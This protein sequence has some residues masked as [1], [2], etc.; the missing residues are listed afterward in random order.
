MSYQSL[1]I[2]Q[3]IN[4]LNKKY[5]LPSLQREFVWDDRQI[6]RLFDS[7]MRGYPISSFLFWQPESST[8]RCWTTYKFL[9]EIRDGGSHSSIANLN[10][11]NHPVFVLDGQQRLTAL[12]IG[13]RGFYHAKE[14]YRWWNNPDAYKATRLHIDLIRKGI[15]TGADDED[16]E[17]HFR[18]SFTDSPAKTTKKSCWFEVGKILNCK[19]RDKLYACI[20]KVQRS[21]PKSASQDARSS[22]ADTLRTLYEAIFETPTIFY[23]TETLPDYDRVLDI[24]VRANEAGT[25]LT[26]SDLLLSTMIAN[27]AHEDARKEIHTFVDH[28]ND[29]LGRRNDLDK[30]FVIKASF[31]LCDLP[32]KYNITSFTRRNL[33]VVEQS[34]PDIKSALERCLNLVNSFGIDR[35]NLSSAN[36]LIPVA[37]YLFNNPGETLLGGSR[38]ES[39]N[40]NTIRRWLL[41]ALLNGVFGGSSDTMLSALRDVLRSFGKRGRDFPVDKLNKTIAQRGRSAD[42]DDKAME[43]LLSLEYGDHNT[44][45]ALSLLYDEKAW[46]NITHHKDHIFPKREFTDTGLRRAGVPKASRERFF[47]AKDHIANLQLLT[48]RENTQKRAQEFKV[49]IRTRSQNFRHKHLIPK[50]R[51]LH[52]LKQFEKFLENRERLIRSRLNR[53]FA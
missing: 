23:H 18:F 44:F 25:K 40:A 11:V 8:A 48:D 50:S 47:E 26:K 14:K 16:L 38:W 20:R 3:A 13:L 31:V 2:H 37:Y 4:R 17:T 43:K 52:S 46:G 29:H 51:R 28:L 12:N 10:G 21:L 42:F 9:E 41:M 34:W 36:A 27:W 5:F 19:N 24:F 22:V 49:W 53:L 30:D 7:I 39:G 15:G 1:T 6:I 35:E 32:V 45:L 33:K